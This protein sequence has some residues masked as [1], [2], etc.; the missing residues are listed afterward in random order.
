LTDEQAA[1]FRQLLTA[2]REMDID[3]YFTSD[4]P[5]VARVLSAVRLL[6]GR[7]GEDLITDPEAGNS[8]DDT[9]ADDEPTTAGAEMAEPGYASMG[10]AKCYR[11]G[12]AT[13]REVVR[14][15]LAPNTE[16][17]AFVKNREALR[18]GAMGPILPSLED[19]AAEKLADRVFGKK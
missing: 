5:A 19:Q 7:E 16:R 18:P 14:M 15:S 8:G 9:G 12:R 2:L 4:S 17:D 13:L 3:Q 10:L 6:W 11:S 1:G